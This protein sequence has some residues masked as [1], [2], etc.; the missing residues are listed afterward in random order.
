MCYIVINDLSYLTLYNKKELA[1]GGH[2][3]DRFGWSSV[4]NAFYL[5]Y[6]NLQWFYQDIIITEIEERAVLTLSNNAPSGQRIFSK[7]TKTWF[8]IIILIHESYETEQKGVKMQS[9]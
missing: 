8:K 3:E 4:L 5:R 7:K 2:A 6:F 1:I 9:R